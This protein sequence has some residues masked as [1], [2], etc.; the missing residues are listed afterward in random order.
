LFKE[1]KK[2][3]EIELQAGKGNVNDGR[4][5]RN[6]SRRHWK[7]AVNLQYFQQATINPNF[8]RNVAIFTVSKGSRF[9]TWYQLPVPT[10][11]SPPI[12]Q[13]TR[14]DNRYSKLKKCTKLTFYW[15]AAQLLPAEASLPVC[16]ACQKC[17]HLPWIPED[18][19]P[20]V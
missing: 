15:L 10:Q 1:R 14:L 6:C 13:V 9:V 4:R 17:F 16:H 11:H 5:G 19:A 8:K 18:L 7:D 20:C 2:N 3:G 12:I